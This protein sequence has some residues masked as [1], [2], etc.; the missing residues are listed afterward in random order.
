MKASLL[1]LTLLILG[2]AMGGCAR[3]VR[4]TPPRLYRE[5]LTQPVPPAAY[6]R[7]PD[8]LEQP[9]GPSDPSSRPHGHAHNVQKRQEAKFEAPEIDPATDR[10]PH[11]GHGGQ[12]R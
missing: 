11:S 2:P 7:P 10:D 1:V 6:V 3:I 9:V 12:S 8:E 5:F 4:T